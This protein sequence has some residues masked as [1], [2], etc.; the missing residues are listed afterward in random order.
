MKTRKSRVAPLAIAVVVLLV[1]GLLAIASASG[2]DD[3]EP[4]MGDQELQTLYGE[5]AAEAQKLWPDEYAW[6]WQR[7][8]G[9]PEAGV[10]IGF[11]EDADGKVE[12]LAK[13]FPRPELLYP[14]EVPI[15]DKEMN[16]RIDLVVAD[17]SVASKGEGALAEFSPEFD[18]ME[19]LRSGEVIVESPRVSDEFKQALQETY[20]FP[21]RYEYGGVGQL[22]SCVSRTDCIDLR[23]GIQSRNY[24]AQIKRC[25][26]GFTVLW[27][28][29]VAQ[30]N[31]RQ[32]LSAAHCTRPD[33]TLPVYHHRAIGE[34]R[35]HGP[36]P[37]PFGEV[38]ALSFA[39]SVDVERISTY[40]NPGFLARP[41]IYFL[42][43]FQ[44]LQVLGMRYYS[45]MVGNEFI[46]RSGNTT[47]TQCGYI[48]RKDY[49]PATEFGHTNFVRFSACSAGGDSGGPVYIGNT[50]YGVYDGWIDA[51]ETPGCD[52]NDP[53]VTHSFFGPIYQAVNAVDANLLLYQPPPP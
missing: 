19:D 20:D 32:M 11:T 31:R 36:G 12:Y 40:A 17:R 2:Q 30:V 41:L 48:L 53:T 1:G 15:S 37:N 6:V 47:D 23:A 3:R 25:S 38:R 5:L 7:E 33:L 35:W 49:S 18:V 42:D 24:Q 43:T 29:A 45:Q 39:N 28:D 44:D 26:L 22:G 4:A 21:I 27:W 8:R 52:P 46:C 34:Q 9:N 51:D 16:K 10:E 50:A 13:D 14:L